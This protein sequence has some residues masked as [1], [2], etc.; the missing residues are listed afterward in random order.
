MAARRTS[1]DQV[2]FALF[3]LCI[4]G[5]AYSHAPGCEIA[6]LNDDGSVDAT[7]LALF[8]ACMNGANRPPPC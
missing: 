2:D 5:S 6:D 1:R 3:Q 8:L 4:S 7:D